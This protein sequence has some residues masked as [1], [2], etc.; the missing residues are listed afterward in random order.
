MDINEKLDTIMNMV[1]GIT[2]KLEEH[3]KKFDLI[4]K[5]FDAIDEKFDTIDKK[6]D[7]I[8]KRFD[9]IDEKFDT[10]D[11][12]FDAIDKRFDA[13]DEKFDTIDKRFDAIDE[14]F[15]TIDKRFDAIDLRIDILTGSNREE[16][17]KMMVLITNLAS[18]FTRFEAEYTDK[19]KILFD[20]TQ[21]YI[22]HKS[23]SALQLTSLEEK[24]KNNSFRI[25]KL[26]KAI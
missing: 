8:D 3:D 13:I 10:I 12:R 11:K 20:M 19:Y 14:K 26:E 23:I 25:S 18:S 2:L 5:K 16:H 24:V 1:K 4:G 17:E 21:D 9:A 22:E 7:T 15:D 6:F